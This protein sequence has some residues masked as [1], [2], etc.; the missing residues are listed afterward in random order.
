[1]YQI[2]FILLYCYLYHPYTYVLSLTK[3]A[4]VRL[5]RLVPIPAVSPGSIFK[6]FFFFTSVWRS[7]KVLQT[8]NQ[9]TYCTYYHYQTTP[10]NAFS[11]ASY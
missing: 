2:Y 6:L 5:E 1:M 4:A 7:N 9:H 11:F 10:M 8:A 3:Y